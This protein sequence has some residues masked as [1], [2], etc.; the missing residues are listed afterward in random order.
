MLPNLFTWL[1]LPH[2]PQVPEHFVQRALDIAKDAESK[3][4]TDDNK[5][6]SLGIARPEDYKR[7]LIQNGE[8]INTRIQ[9][10]FFMGEDWEQWVRENIFPRFTETSVRPSLGDSRTHGPHCDNP[11][12]IRLYYLLDRGGEDAE[13]VFYHKPGTGNA[14]WDVDKHYEENNKAP[15]LCNN[16]DELEVIDRVKFPLHQWVLFNGYVLHGVN[17]VDH[18]RVNLNVSI[19]PEDFT[20]D[21]RPT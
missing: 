5:I 13:T 12:K 8:E 1:P 16:I 20:F 18:M 19:R 7:K 2:L 15:I 21:I 11:G 14:V 9:R 3:T 10:V 6:F 17:N 4:W